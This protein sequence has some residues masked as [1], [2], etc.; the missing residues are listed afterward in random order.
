M[1]Y[2]DRSVIH[3][4]YLTILFTLAAISRAIFKRTSSVHGGKLAT[5]S[6]VL[7]LIVSGMILQLI[8]EAIRANTTGECFRGAWMLTGHPGIVGSEDLIRTL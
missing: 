2:S 4:V 7:I 3:I 6:H 8:V 5:T 1:A